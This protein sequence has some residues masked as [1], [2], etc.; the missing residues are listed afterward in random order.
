[1]HRGN[2][3]GYHEGERGCECT[4]ETTGVIMKERECAQGETTGVIMKEREC[5]QGETTG[6]IM[7]EREGVDAQG[8]QLGLS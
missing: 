7:K 1:M 8:K 2:N 5:A 3:W 6:V 4:G